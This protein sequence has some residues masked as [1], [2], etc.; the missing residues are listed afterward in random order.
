VASSAVPLPRGA[1]VALAFALL[2]LGVGA[3]TM[4]WRKGTGRVAA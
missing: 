3:T 2:G 4:R 1:I